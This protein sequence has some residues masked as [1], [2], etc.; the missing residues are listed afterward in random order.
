MVEIEEHKGCFEWVRLAVTHEDFWKRDAAGEY[1]LLGFPVKAGISAKIRDAYIEEFGD[2]CVEADAIS[3]IEIVQITFDPRTHRS[4][5][6]KT[7]GI[8]VPDV[9]HLHLDLL[10]RKT[11]HKVVELN[12]WAARRSHESSLKRSWVAGL[13]PTSLSRFHASLIRRAELS[14]A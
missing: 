9:I 14:T 4:L 3:P 1:E 2:R 13:N 11:F 7:C 6:R 10:S 5:N 12:H 8:M